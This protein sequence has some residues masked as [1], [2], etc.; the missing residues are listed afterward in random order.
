MN[1]RALRVET[2]RPIRKL[3]GL[4]EREDGRM[5]KRDN[6]GDEEMWTLLPKAVVLVVLNAAGV[7]WHR[8]RG[9]THQ[10]LDPCL[11]SAPDR[12][13]LWCGLIQVSPL[14]AFWKPVDP[15]HFPAPAVSKPRVEFPLAIQHRRDLSRRKSLR[16]A[17]KLK[18]P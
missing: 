16:I 6:Q 5:D 12:A 15:V 2:G 17:P 10:A 4:Q 7:E 13:V 3:C 1:C 18:F 9:P 8:P 11:T 14:K